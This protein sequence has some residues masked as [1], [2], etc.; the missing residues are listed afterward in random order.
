MKPV[1]AIGII[2]RHIPVKKGN[3]CL[4]RWTTDKRFHN[5]F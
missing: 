2:A 3:L 1:C 4:E 5:F